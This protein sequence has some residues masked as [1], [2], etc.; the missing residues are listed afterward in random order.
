MYSKTKFLRYVAS[1]S[2][3]FFF[4]WVTFAL[5][6]PMSSAA[7]VLLKETKERRQCD[8]IKKTL[9]NSKSSLWNKVL[10]CLTCPYAK[11][12][13]DVVY[14]KINADDWFWILWEVKVEFF[15]CHKGLDIILIY[16]NCTVCS[17]S[18]YCCCSFCLYYIVSFFAFRHCSTK[19]GKCCFSNLL[20]LLFWNETT[21]LLLFLSI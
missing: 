3:S 19:I 2:F 12:T 8:L 10:K 18:F 7:V 5:Q 13:P 20:N 4:F 17:F 21:K 11:N 14:D 9:L 6:M 16:F 15:L 1:F